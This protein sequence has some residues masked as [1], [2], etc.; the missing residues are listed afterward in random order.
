MAP[1]LSLEAHM[2]IMELLRRGWSRVAIAKS[3]RV[4]EGTVRYHDRRRLG[5]R[6][7]LHREPAVGAVLF[8]SSL[9]TAAA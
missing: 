8:P 5:H 3:L 2:T 4:T 6:A 1:K 7:W 9:C